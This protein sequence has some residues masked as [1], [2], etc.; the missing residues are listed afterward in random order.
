MELIPWLAQNW[1]ELLVAV[2]LVAVYVVI[3]DTRKRIESLE[4]IAHTLILLHSQ[5]HKEDAIKFI[6]GGRNEAA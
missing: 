2:V 3:R 4:R 6:P 1:P 5:Y